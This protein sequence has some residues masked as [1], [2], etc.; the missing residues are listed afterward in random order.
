MNPEVAARAPQS[1]PVN[2]PRTCMHSR[3]ISD[4]V[5]EEEQNAEKV[6]YVECGDVIPDP[7]LSRES[8]GTESLLPSVFAVA[9]K[10]QPPSNNLKDH[11]SRN[12]NPCRCRP[13]ITCIS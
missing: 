12:H 1:L 11:R 8:N 7:S 5:T 3:L 13:A 2:S 4:L 6:R 9:R 10:H